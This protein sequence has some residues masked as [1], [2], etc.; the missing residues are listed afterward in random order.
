MIAAV[1]ALIDLP[2]HAPFVPVRMFWIHDRPAERRAADT[3]TRHA[4]SSSFA[5]AAASASMRSTER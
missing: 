1:L 3:P 5:F 2:G 4:A